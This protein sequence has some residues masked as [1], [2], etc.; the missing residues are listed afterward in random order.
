M[1]RAGSLPELL[2][3]CALRAQH[4]RFAG[5]PA[6]SARGIPAGVDRA[7]A[8]AVNAG[9]SSSPCSIQPPRRLP[10]PSAPGSLRE[11]PRGVPSSGCAWTPYVS[12]KPPRGACQT[13]R[14]RVDVIGKGRCSRAREGKAGD[15]A[16]CQKRARRCP[17]ARARGKRPKALIGGGGFSSHGIPVVIECSLLADV[18]H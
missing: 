15:T 1:T 17:R 10:A 9:C 7:R 6:R 8:G 18:L 2:S 13:K 5:V 3:C 4:A 11:P 14:S 12:S 16:Q